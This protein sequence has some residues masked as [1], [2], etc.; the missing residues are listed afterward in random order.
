MGAQGPR[1]FEEGVDGGR[2][3]HTVRPCSSVLCGRKAGSAH[4]LDC[5][6]DCNFSDLTARGP[7]TWRNQA[8]H[9][10]GGSFSAVSWQVDVTSRLNHHHAASDAVEAGAHA[11]AVQGDRVAGR[12]GWRRLLD[13]PR[14]ARPGQL[15][16]RLS[17]E[18]N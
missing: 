15:G 13:E 12:K 9:A 10:C 6:Q 3:E 5:M 2:C 1:R 16:E 14:P 18:E 8:Q 17:P 4:C 7:Y 11:L